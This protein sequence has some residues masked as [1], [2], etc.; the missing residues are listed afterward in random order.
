MISLTFEVNKQILKKSNDFPKVIRGSKGILECQFIFGDEWANY[1]VS[2]IF[3][4]STRSVV[5]M[6]TVI[7][8]TC[9]IPDSVTDGKYFFIKLIGAKS[10]EQYTY[11]NTIIVDQ[12]D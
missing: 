4:D 10:T 1:A 8:S 9:K 12:E 5:E 6:V 2:A 11:T 7:D 3:Q